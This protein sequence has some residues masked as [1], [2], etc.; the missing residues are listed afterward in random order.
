MIQVTR[1]IQKGNPQKIRKIRLHLGLSQEKFARHL[2]VALNTLSRWET[3]LIVPPRVAELA[4]EYLLLAHK[5]K[6]STNWRYSFRR[7]SDSFPNQ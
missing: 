5:P 1:T 7:P 4:A 2:G 3:G 6:V